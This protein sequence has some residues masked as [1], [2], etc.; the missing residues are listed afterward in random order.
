MCDA[1]PNLDVK[2]LVRAFR[3]SAYAASASC[4]TWFVG[5]PTRRNSDWYIGA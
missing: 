4:Q 2:E 3:I 1:A 5:S